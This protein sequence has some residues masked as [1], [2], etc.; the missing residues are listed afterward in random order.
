M[1]KK[2]KASRNIS[3]QA[4]GRRVIATGRTEEAINE[5]A[6]KGLRPLIKA[7]QPGQEIWAQMLIFQDPLT[8]EIE[9]RGDRRWAPGGKELVLFARYYPYSFPSPFAAY[10]LPSDLKPGE[11]VWLEDLIEDVVGSHWGQ[12]PKWRLEACAAVWNGEDFELLYD[13]LRDVQEFIG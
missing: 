2:K 12:G 10:L 6:R 1:K 5:A 7:V 8:G 13:P 3:E 4:A 9:V 11:E